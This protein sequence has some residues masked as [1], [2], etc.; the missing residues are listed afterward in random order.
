VKDSKRETVQTL[1]IHDYPEQFKNA[2]W[3]ATTSL[4]TNKSYVLKNHACP[5]STTRS[6][7]TIPVIAHIVS[8]Y[9][10]ATTEN[11]LLCVRRNKKE[12]YKN[13]FLGAFDILID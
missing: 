8:K 7:P 10:L 3:H 2:S 6:D 4:L 13:S 12:Q 5:F 1:Y 11:T 9:L